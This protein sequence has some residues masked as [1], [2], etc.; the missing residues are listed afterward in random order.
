M[1]NFEF[2]RYLIK[3][4]HDYASKRDNELWLIFV[5][6]LTYTTHVVDAH[7]RE[8][9]FSLLWLVSFFCGNHWLIKHLKAPNYTC[10]FLYN[11]VN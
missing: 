9:R 6:F 7:H 10:I 8:N 4:K 11:Q 3:D 5:G 2:V 1:S